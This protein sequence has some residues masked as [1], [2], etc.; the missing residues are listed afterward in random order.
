M[1]KPVQECTNDLQPQLC[2]PLC[3]SIHVITGHTQGLALYPTGASQ[4]SLAEETSGDVVSDM[5]AINTLAP[6][7]LTRAAL[8]A[9]LARGRG[10]IVVISS[11]AGRIPS[12]GQAIYSAC[13]AAVNFYFSTLLT[14]IHDRCM[15]NL[16]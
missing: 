9:M 8:P 15:A 6:I 5:F 7:A 13:K 14:E 16:A 4:H 10:R 12:P 11:M 1:L 3:I 2:G